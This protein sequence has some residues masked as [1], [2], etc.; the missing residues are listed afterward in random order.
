MLAVEGAIE[1][2]GEDE[3]RSDEPLLLV[4]L[5]E[6]APEVPPRDEF[7]SELLTGPVEV[8]RRRAF[9]SSWI[10][11]NFFDAFGLRFGRAAAGVML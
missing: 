11:F 5:V 3:P 1:V 7:R 10:C 4:W 8:R 2:R 6:S 9:S